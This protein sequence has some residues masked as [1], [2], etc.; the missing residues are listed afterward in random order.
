M[1][2]HLIHID[3]ISDIVCPWC[4][5]GKRQLDH[6]I[7]QNLDIDVQIKWHP[8]MLDPTVPSDGVPYKDYMKQKFGDGPSDRF[9]SMREHLE[10][11]AGPLGINFRFDGIPMRPNTL[12]AHC[13]MKWAQGQ[14]KGHEMSE[15]LFKAFFDEHR[16]VGDTKT[17]AKI[18][19]EV[20][21]D[22]ALV[23]ELLESG[24]DTETVQA[25]LDYFR[26]LGI[27]GVPFFIYNGQFSVQGGQP[28][29]IHSQA[30]VKAQD[31]P[32]KDVMTLLAN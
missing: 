23:T 16:D 18:G 13:L 22:S 5:Y 9:K 20:G 7:A 27:S 26:N 12:K 15:R 29:E 4:W 2:E 1:A 32:P 6:A 8:F 31:L 11:G 25:E 21:M 30:L 19:K 10:T 14:D 3:I 24:R 17:L 28:A